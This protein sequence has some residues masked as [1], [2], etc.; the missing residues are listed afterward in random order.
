[1]ARMLSVCQKI[2]LNR[3]NHLTEFKYKDEIEMTINQTG[4]LEELKHAEEVVK[5]LVT[6]WGDIIIGGDLLTVE[7]VDQNKS[8]TS[9]N[10]TEFEKMGFL[11]PSRIAIFHFR[12]NI[13]LKVVAKLLPNLNDSNNPG[14]LN[15][16]R[17]LTA[18][19]KEIS[20]KVCPTFRK[21]K[22]K[23]NLKISGQ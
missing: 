13:V 11:G 15:C 10:L 1:M 14:S 16:F 22:K 7:R 18:K 20:N 23:I 5:D 3:L 9:C 8:L 19:S 12:Q 2:V 17:A 21:I 4:T 6:D